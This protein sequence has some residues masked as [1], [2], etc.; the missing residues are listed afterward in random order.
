[1]IGKIKNF[2]AGS[3]EE[4]RKVI[5]PSKKEVISHTLIVIISIAVSM[6]IIA[7]VDLGLFT[8]VQMLIEKG[9]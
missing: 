7:L 8:I 5:W 4:F 2:F 9:K 1:M 3:Y 6:L